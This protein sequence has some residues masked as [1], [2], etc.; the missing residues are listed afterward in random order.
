M[1]INPARHFKMDNYI[2]FI[3]PG[4]YADITVI[5]SL[6]KQVLLTICNRYVQA[7]DG[8]F[9]GALKSTLAHAML[10]IL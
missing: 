3:T 6:E 2:G 7:K 9:V 5:K 1:T 8:R 10:L 4:G